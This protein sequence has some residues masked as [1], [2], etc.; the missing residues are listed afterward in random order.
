MGPEVHA[1]LSDD[2]RRAVYRLLLGVANADRR[3][4]RAESAILEEHRAFFERSA[5]RTRRYSR[6]PPFRASIDSRPKNSPRSMVSLAPLRVR[7]RRWPTS[8]G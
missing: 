6:S 4:T 3:T 1:H 2:A 8:A 7:S 5:G